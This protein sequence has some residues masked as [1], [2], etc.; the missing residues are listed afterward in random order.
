MSS[1]EWIDVITAIGQ[2]WPF[3]LVVFLIIVAVVYRKYFKSLLDNTTNVQLKYGDKEVNVTKEKESLTKKLED[4]NTD[5]LATQPTNEKLSKIESEDKSDNESEEASYSVLNKVVVADR[6]YNRA[7]S[8]YKELL[9][10]EESD[11]ERKKLYYYYHGLRLISGQTEAEQDI[12]NAIKEETNREYVA[13]GY[14]MLG[15]AYQTIDAQKTAIREFQRALQLDISTEKTVQAISSIARAR[16]ELE[17]Y[18]GAISI[19]NDYYDRVNAD[20]DRIELIKLYSQALGE[21]NDK[22]DSSVLLG[23]I[24]GL[25][26]ANASA[27]FDAAYQFAEEK[28]NLQA[29]ILYQKLLSIQSDYHGV[30]NNLGLLFAELDL[31]I[32]SIDSL[33]RATNHGNSL[34]ASN[35]ANKYI[36]A[37]MTEEA[38]NALEKALTFEVVNSNVHHSLA[39]IRRETDTEERNLK[40]KIKKAQR[41]LYLFDEYARSLLIKLNKDKI[42]ATEWKIKETGEV[43]RVSINNDNINLIWKNY[44]SLE[45]TV[46]GTLNNSSGKATYTSQTYQN[47]NPLDFMWNK[48]KLS[49][50]VVVKKTFTGRLYIHETIIKFFEVVDQKVGSTT[51][52]IYTNSPNTAPSV[53]RGS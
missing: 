23:Y 52:N 48:D 50:P 32:K 11:L 49:E 51:V 28:F 46:A 9:K 13:E 37:G 43:V 19:I 31:P 42:L 15:H 1:K 12:R 24:V 4:D 25:Q 39:R 30:N 10:N 17:E 6:D 8:I 53:N 3:I 5:V 22:F 18:D 38:K 35:L 21:I 26:P 36:D 34:A 47:T 33:K 40:G 20:E 7:E 44:R 29:M 27:I 45:C 16:I 2:Q 14:I 41:D